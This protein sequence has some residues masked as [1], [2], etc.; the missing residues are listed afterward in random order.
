MTYP[1]T[2]G[3]DYVKYLLVERAKTPSRRAVLTRIGHLIDHMYRMSGEFAEKR[4]KPTFSQKAIECAYKAEALIDLLEVHDCG[5]PGGW[6]NGE[7][8][9]YSLEERYALLQRK[10][11]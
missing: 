10:Y 11:T 3:N 2:Q 7:N 6:D 5:F 8:G 9:L 4:V 1:Q